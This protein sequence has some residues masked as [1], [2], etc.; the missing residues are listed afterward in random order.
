MQR[1][2]LCEHL[3]IAFVSEESANVL[4]ELLPVLYRAQEF[5]I[6]VARRHDAA[7]V[8]EGV[9]CHANQLPRLHDIIVDIL[10]QR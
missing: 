6:T 10:S 3:L 2:R 8:D 9:G 5:H 7:E 4:V 1:L